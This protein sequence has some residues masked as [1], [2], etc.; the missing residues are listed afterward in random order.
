M[1]IILLIFHFSDSPCGLAIGT[2]RNLLALLVVEVSNLRL[3]DFLFLSELFH[4]LL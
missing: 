2:L 1:L 4:F 3:F